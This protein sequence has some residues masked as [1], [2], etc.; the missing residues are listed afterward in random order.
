MFS[1]VNLILAI[2]VFYMNGLWLFPAFFEKK[3][4]GL[5]ILVNLVA[6]GL[7][8]HIFFKLD[9]LLKSVNLISLIFSLIYKVRSQEH[10]E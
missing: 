10:T 6:L 4:Y 1:V 2:T 7:L 9:A 8:S 5:Y 3:R